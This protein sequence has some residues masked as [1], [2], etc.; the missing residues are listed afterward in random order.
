MAAQAGRMG[1]ISSVAQSSQICHCEKAQRGA[2]SAKSEE[3]PLG[4]NHGKAVA[5]SPRADRY[6]T[7][8]CEIATSLRSSQ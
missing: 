6:P 5:I 1:H 7:E 4:C 2:L 8:Y 3:V